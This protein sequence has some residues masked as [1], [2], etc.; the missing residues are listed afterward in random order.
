MPPVES[1]PSLKV[2]ISVYA[3]APNVGSEPGVG[4]NIVCALAKHHELY[5]FTRASNAP[6]IEAELSKQP[7]DNLN[8]IYFD[9]PTWAAWLPPANVA[10]YYFWQIEAYAVA[11]ELLRTQPIHL[12]HHITY[13]RYS[14]PSFLS[15]L[16]LPF[17]FGPV[18]GGEQAPSTFWQ[19]FSLRGKV[20]NVLRNLSHKVGELDPFTR[21]TARRS[22]LVRATTVD[23]AARLKKLGAAN[24]QVASALGLS[25]EEIDQLAQQPDP[26]PAPIR[27]ISI[28]R[29]LHWK[30]IYL[31]LQAF[32]DVVQHS[33][34]LNE[35]EYW[36]LG[37]GP[38]RDRLGT[39]A[40]ELDIAKQVKFLGVLPRD[41]T[42]QKIAECHV[43]LHPSLHDS[44]GFVCLEAM[45]AGRPVICLDLGGP[46]VQ[47]TPA[48][49]VLVP[50]ED[51][52]Q[53]VR[54]LSQ[55]MV[56]LATDHPLRAQ[57]GAAGRQHVLEN[58]VWEAKAQQLAQLYRDCVEQQPVDMSPSVLESQESNC[59]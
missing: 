29:L 55:A 10:H 35:C 51:P 41:Q 25:Q 4:W 31:G 6:A 15:L 40:D 2:L 58:Y 37:E 28:A 59:T 16:P 54:S 11:K 42:L 32:A 53:A 33:D 26:P 39:L 22:F 56:K 14:T 7:I 17:I 18:G 24:V 12:V 9:P 44:G 52:K 47:V 50:A 13:V 34:S 57:M 49:G 45:A 36:I 21:A 48:A 46:A 8:F 19:S 3:C 30:G 38:E 5:V 27:F 23:T 1:Y 43:L 20:Y